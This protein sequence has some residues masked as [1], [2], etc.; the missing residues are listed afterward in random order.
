LTRRSGAGQVDNRGRKAKKDGPF[1]K[2]GKGR[3]GVRPLEEGEQAKGEK[4]GKPRGKVAP[5][6]RRIDH[7]KERSTSTASRKKE[8]RFS[9]PREARERGEKRTHGPSF[10][11]HPLLSKKE[12]KSV[13]PFLAAH[14]G[15]KKRKKRWS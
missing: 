9:P 5:C 2:R 7:L 1:R 15:K 13:P 6:V 12:R 11:R 3:G 8:T 10:H 4:K 14:F